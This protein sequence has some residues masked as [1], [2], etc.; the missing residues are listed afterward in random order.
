MEKR[1]SQV[2]STADGLV[3]IRAGAQASTLGISD[4]FAPWFVTSE[5]H[6]L[7]NMAKATDP[8]YEK[9]NLSR[10]QYTTSRLQELVTTYEQVIL[11]G[12]GFDCR[13]LSL[14]SFKSGK[15]KVFEVDTA[16]KLDQKSRT[17][18]DNDSEIPEWNLYVRAD[19]RTDNLRQKL[20]TA[21][22]NPTLSTL[23]LAEG[24]TYF[25]PPDVSQLL[26][27][28]QTLGLETGSRLIFD[29]WT[30]SRVE[31]LNRRV[32]ERI[33]FELFHPFPLSVQPN[34]LTKALIDIGYRDA[35]IK[36]LSEIAAQSWGY[37]IQDD[38]GLSW[39]MVEVVL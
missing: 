7:V 39:Y 16:S 28:P 14:E 4:P 38:F 31:S 10:F 23:I 21:G 17:L 1:D 26:V 18:H 19:L 35:T 6:K 33:G 30:E 5:G 8:V 11:L 9:F 2:G 12:A 25:I 29:C 24:L 37:A 32:K 34:A 36:P 22:F 13:A 3:V 27:Q 15:V 20:V